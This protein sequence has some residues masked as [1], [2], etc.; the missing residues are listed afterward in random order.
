MSV[1]SAPAAP[2]VRPGIALQRARWAVVALSWLFVA[3]A[4]AF[5]L[6]F[7]N[8]TADD[9]YITF[10]YA[11]N[12]VDHGQWSW[13]P[14]HV[15][16]DV[17]AYT[18]PLFA[19]LAIPVHWLGLP[20]M[21]PFKLL[22]L[23]VLFFV[24]RVMLRGLPPARQA[25]AAAFVC[26]NFYVFPHAFSGLETDVFLLAALLALDADEDALCGPA[27]SA[28]LLVAPLIRPEGALIS[29]HILYTQA[30]LRRMNRWTGLFIALG[31]A[32]MAWRVHRYGQWLPNTYYAKMNQAS[33]FM[34]NLHAER[35][36]VALGV[37]SLWV[38]HRAGRPVLLPAALLLGFVFGNLR[39][40]MQMNY[41][42][43]FSYHTVVPVALHAA[44]VLLMRMPSP[45][46][47][48]LPRLLDA[49][50]LA[51]MFALAVATLSLHVSFMML[52]QY[53]QAITMHRELAQ[54][55]RTH[56]PPSAI[57]AAEDVG[58]L[59]YH[60]GLTTIDYVGLASR[61]VTGHLRGEAARL[62]P[63]DVI[64][65]YGASAQSCEPVTR[66]AGIQALKPHLSDKARYACVAGMRFAPRLHLNALVR[67]D[68]PHGAALAEAIAR[69]GAQASMQ[70]YSRW[71]VMS[72]ALRWKGLREDMATR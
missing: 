21:P 13:N 39:A 7:A 4:S 57:V 28:M 43:R 44:R 27:F 34:D 11:R 30:R 17:E 70:E 61:E 59:P 66:F 22:G 19:A 3:A 38:L 36:A 2:S 49:V 63:P 62:P 33:S 58:V 10:R 16:Q 14:G 45:L 50:C 41:L 31:L 15:L 53:T 72:D 35:Y 51:G 48:A 29:M 40:D 60:A 67:Q 25:V 42:H 20:A 32:Y 64:L 8:F 23:G 52:G 69:Q 68:L 54:V 6:L 37:L 1:A 71:Q 24:F 56:A 46:P 55:L 5:G 12:L 26:A 18:N 65:L 9:A 47:P